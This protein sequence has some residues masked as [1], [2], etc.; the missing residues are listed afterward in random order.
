MGMAMELEPKEMPNPVR[1]KGMVRAMVT[2]MQ[3]P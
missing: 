3:Q 2:L 1:K